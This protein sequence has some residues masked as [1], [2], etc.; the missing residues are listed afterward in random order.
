MDSEPQDTA[1]AA[2]TRRFLLDYPY[3]AARQFENMPA[4]EAA[5]LLV[6]Q[7]PHACLRAWKRSAPTWRW[8]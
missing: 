8:R 7:P 3:E 4:A 6:N 2:L 5:A 1:E